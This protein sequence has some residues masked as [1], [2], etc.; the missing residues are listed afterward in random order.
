MTTTFSSLD[1]IRVAVGTDLGSSR[2]F[3]LT[4]DR[5]NSFADTTEDRQWIHVDPER[6]AGGPF[7]TTVAHGFLTLSLVAAI[8]GDV[9]QTHWATAGINYGLN[10]VRFP[11]PAPVG[12]RVR[13]HI[14][15]LEVTD[16][17]GGV[18]M[19]SQV[20]IEREGSDRPVCVAESVTRILA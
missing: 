15:L 3:E 18:Q 2:W 12:S 13:G 7:G 14:R 5:I 8:I 20:T 19:I 11:A 9:I 17:S 1:D 4:Q 10:K 6:A 16:I